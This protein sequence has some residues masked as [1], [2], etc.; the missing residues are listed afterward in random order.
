MSEFFIARASRRLG[1]GRIAVS[2]ILNRFAGRWE[3]TEYLRNPWG[4]QFL[5]AGGR[6]LHPRLLSGTSDQRRGTPDFR[7][8]G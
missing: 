3:I 4:C 1:V 8:K 6:G 2:L 7:F 5:A